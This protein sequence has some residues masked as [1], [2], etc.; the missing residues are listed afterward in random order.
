MMGYRRGYRGTPEI[1]PA[2]ADI[3]TR[4]FELY[5]MGY[6]RAGISKEIGSIK[7]HLRDKPYTLGSGTIQAMLRNERFCG[8]V[9]LQ[10]RYVWN[11]IM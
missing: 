1:I 3:I 5:L 4:V 7:T 11:V 6:T 10:K 9:V 2:E 8:D